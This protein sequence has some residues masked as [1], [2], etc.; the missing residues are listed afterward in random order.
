MDKATKVGAS[1][2]PSDR[3][4]PTTAG[5]RRV[6]APSVQCQHAIVDSIRPRSC[7]NAHPGIAKPRQQLAMLQQVLD[8]DRDVVGQ[9]RV[10]RRAS[11]RRSAGVRR[12]VEEDRDRRR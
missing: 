3:K 11:A 10:A 8:L 7:T 2:M 6:Y 5:S 1:V 9:V 12:T 4:G